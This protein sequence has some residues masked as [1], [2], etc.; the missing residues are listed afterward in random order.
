MTITIGTQRNLKDAHYIGRNGDSSLGNP[1]AAAGNT[2]A[3]VVKGYR[4]YLNLVT[5]KGIEPGQAAWQVRRDFP[6]LK[7]QI[8]TAWRIPSASEVMEELL[9]L[10]ENLSQGNPQALACHCYNQPQEWTG[11]YQYRCHAEPIA[12]WLMWQLAQDKLPTA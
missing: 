3:N 1:Y 9:A 7:L 12:G 5:R 2:V 4:Y 11:E 10:Y 8:A 6:D